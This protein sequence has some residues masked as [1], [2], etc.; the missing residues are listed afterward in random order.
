MAAMVSVA[1]TA[2]P[3][4]LDKGC[5]FVC[6]HI[7]ACEEQE[8]KSFCWMENQTCRGLFVLDGSLVQFD[9]PL[10]M[11]KELRPLACDMAVELERRTFGSSTLNTRVQ[12][13]EEEL[14]EEFGE[15]LEGE[16]GVPEEEGSDDEDDAEEPATGSS[17]LGTLACGLGQVCS[18]PM[19]VARKSTHV[20]V[21]TRAWW[22]KPW[23]L[24]R[25]TDTGSSWLRW[26][27]SSMCPDVL[28]CL[29]RGVE[30][31]LSGNT[32]MAKSFM[33]QGAFL[34]KTGRAIP[35]TV[36]VQRQSVS[37]QFLAL[38][39]VRWNR[40]KINM[41]LFVNK[42]SLWSGQNEAVAA[43]IDVGLPSADYYQWSAMTNCYRTSSIKVRQDCLA[44]IRMYMGRG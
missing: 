44:A 15:E 35:V 12:L 41:H 14:G 42:I 17:V 36:N 37:P 24:R 31:Q 1:S 22:A 32:Q 8:L 21:D 18:L 13:G 6:S 3:S 40:P 38:Q 34:A 7:A 28:T 5:A 39:A 30:Y 11:G 19:T 27:G 26:F 16:G 25:W 23:F 20:L 9:P 10:V 2:V 43:L 29:R 4:A 33:E